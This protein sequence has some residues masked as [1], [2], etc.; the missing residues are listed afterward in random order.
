MLPAAAGISECSMPWP[1]L[2]MAFLLEELLRRESSLRTVPPLVYD[3]S[4]VRLGHA[5][6]AVL[7]WLPWFSR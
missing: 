3:D 2:Q 7:K 6:R 5:L 1:A 4:F